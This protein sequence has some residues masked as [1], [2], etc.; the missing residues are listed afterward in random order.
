MHEAET[1]LAK[2]PL[3]VAIHLRWMN[4]G[5]GRG[6]APT[7][8]NAASIDDRCT[9]PAWKHS[10]ALKKTTKPGTI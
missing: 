3:S 7:G 6:T 10:I 8:K 5:R 1:N 9:S 2:L 4:R